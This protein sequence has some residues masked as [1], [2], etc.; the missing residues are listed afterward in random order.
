MEHRQSEPPVMFPP[1][2]PGNPDP[3]Q[4]CL[5]EPDEQ[6]QCKHC[7]RWGKFMEGLGN[8]IGEWK[9]GE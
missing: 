9:F 5:H 6:G 2:S 8:A 3:G 4:Q 1:G 7:G